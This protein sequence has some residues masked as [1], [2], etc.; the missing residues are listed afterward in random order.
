MTLDWRFRMLCFLTT[1]RFL[2][3]AIATLIL[4]SC[5]DVGGKLKQYT[6]EVTRMMDSSDLP[7][8][9]ATSLDQMPDDAATVARAIQQEISGTAQGQA[10][11]VKFAGNLGTRLAQPWSKEACFIPT[12]AQLYLHQANADDPTIN[13]TNGR[14]DFEGPV[15]RRA[16]VRY[17]AL[18]RTAENGILI[19]EAR[20]T[21]IYST[22]PEPL[23]FVVPAQALPTDASGYPNTYAGLLQFVGERA[24][25]PGKTGSVSNQQKDY[26]IFVFFLDLVS[27][28]A[29]LY[30][31]IS[32]EPSGINGY[33]KSTQYVNFGGWHVGL[34]AGQ[35]SLFGDKAIHPLYVKAVFTPGEEVGFLLRTPKLVGLFSLNGSSP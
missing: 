30:V 4:F 17:D 25:Q 2:G 33:G 20:V 19:K 6:H 10:Q 26:V 8:P 34:L 21:Q 31:K 29:N 3:F 24:V 7:E 18:S 5:A 11:K 15:G 9:V 16:S 27:D 28:S 12:G 1:F 13:T 35:F 23:M 14:L 32:N 22:S